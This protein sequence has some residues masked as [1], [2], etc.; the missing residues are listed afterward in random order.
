MQVPGSRCDKDSELLKTKR[1][2]TRAL[3]LFVYSRKID[4]LFAAVAFQRCPVRVQAKGLLAG[5][6]DLAV[7]VNVP[8]Y[9]NY[10]TQPTTLSIAIT[11]IQTTANTD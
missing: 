7:F 9:L 1:R 4:L 11:T 10:T 5:E 6:L 2:S 8:L 3:R